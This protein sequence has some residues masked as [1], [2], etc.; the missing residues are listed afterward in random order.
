MAP[1]TTSGWT[2]HGFLLVVDRHSLSLTTSILFIWYHLYDHNNSSKTHIRTTIQLQTRPNP[3][4]ATV[5]V[6]ML[7]PTKKLMTFVRH[8]SYFTYY[9]GY[10]KI[11]RYKTNIEILWIPYICS[12]PHPISEPGDAASA[13]CKINWGSAGTLRDPVLLGAHFV[14]QSISCSSPE[15][16]GVAMIR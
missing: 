3:N 13:W 8:Q 5:F 4:A 16:G 12:M 2:R 11:E 7:H 10:Q 6:S 1:P 14:N 15:N 9:L